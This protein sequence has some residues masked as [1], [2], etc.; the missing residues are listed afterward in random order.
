MTYC[1]APVLHNL[2]K[3]AWEKRPLIHAL[4]RLQNYLVQGDN[5][6]C[7]MTYHTDR[8]RDENRNN[9]QIND[10][11]LFLKMAQ[12]QNLNII[13]RSN[14]KSN[15]TQLKYTTFNILHYF[16]PVPYI[17]NEIMQVY[18]NR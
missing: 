12:T 14:S 16:A 13:N 15:K 4:S 5:I 18:F 2:R 3:F 7:L 17:Q 1:D 11:M 10:A 6:I 8:W 9:C